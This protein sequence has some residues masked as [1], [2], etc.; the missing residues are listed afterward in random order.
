MTM[1]QTDF[2]AEPALLLSVTDEVLALVLLFL[3]SLLAVPAFSIVALSVPVLMLTSSSSSV[4]SGMPIALT[5][6]TSVPEQ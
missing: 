5:L 6:S 2:V 1:P 4:L 3:V